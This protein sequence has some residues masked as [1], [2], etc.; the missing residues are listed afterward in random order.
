MAAKH[1]IRIAA[2]RASPQGTWIDPKVLAM[3]AAEVEQLQADLALERLKVAKLT[4]KLQTAEA[5]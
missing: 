3:W 5:Q 2:D 1:S 4:E